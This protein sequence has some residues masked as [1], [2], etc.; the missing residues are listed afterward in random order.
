MAAYLHVEV[1]RIHDPVMYRRYVAAA[2]PL[3]QTSGGTYVLTSNHVSA[4]SDHEPPERVVL[5]RFPDRQS[6]DR[7]FRSADYA[8]IAPLRESSTESRAII[9]E[10]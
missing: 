1:S 6:L 9:I 7:C 8:A 5:I 2:R 3:V 10:D 4:L